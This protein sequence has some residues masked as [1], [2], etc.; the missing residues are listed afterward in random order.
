MSPPR[1]EDNDFASFMGHNITSVGGSVVVMVL[2]DMRDCNMLVDVSV[3]RRFWEG[4]GNG[5]CC[6][7]SSPIPLSVMGLLRPLADM[8]MTPEGTASSHMIIQVCICV[9][10]KCLHLESYLGTPYENRE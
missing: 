3:G 10:L 7:H 9:F 6:C 2:E 1:W 5:D 8:F 4:G